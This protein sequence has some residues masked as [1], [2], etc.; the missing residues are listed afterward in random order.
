MLRDNLF[1]RRGDRPL[2]VF[3]RES[4][5][6]A[7]DF[8][9]APIV[10]YV[11]IVRV[12]VHHADRQIGQAL[13]NFFDVADAHAGIE[14]QRLF[15]TDDQVGNDFFLLMRLIDGEEA[16]ADAIDLKPFVRDIDALQLAIGRA[17]QVAAPLRFLVGLR[18][19]NSKEMAT[20]RCIGFAAKDT[21]FDDNQV[22]RIGK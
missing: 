17:R 3:T 7:V 12:G 8:A 20:A 1:L 15:F 9:E 18:S 4:G 19:E 16:G 6:H 10:A 13:D 22:S 21:S 2:G 5:V 14:Q 11:V